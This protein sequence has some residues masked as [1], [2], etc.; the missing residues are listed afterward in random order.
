MTS[1]IDITKYLRAG[2]NNIKVLVLKWCDGSY[3]EDQDMWRSSGIFR[4]V[5]LLYRDP[6]HIVD[7]FA[8]PSLNID[9]TK[10]E[11]SVEIKTTDKTDIAYSLECSCGKVVAEG[12]VSDGNIH[13]DIDSPLLWSDEE[14]NL[15]NLI[16]TCGSEIICIP[17]G[18]RISRSSTRSST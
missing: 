10:G 2:R 17:V 11:L 8:K 15:Y 1:E 12:V 5:Y 16:L 18:F 13:A 4:E 3:L 7:I 14:P 6:V 9:F